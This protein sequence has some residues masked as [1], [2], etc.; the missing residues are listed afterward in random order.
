MA[1]ETT[2]IEKAMMALAQA[3]LDP[4]AASELMARL[5]VTKDDLKAEVAQEIKAEVLKEIEDEFELDADAGHEPTF[6]GLESKRT[7]QMGVGEFETEVK[8][9]WMV[10]LDG[11]RMSALIPDLIRY[12]YKQGPKALEGLSPAKLLQDVMIMFTKKKTRKDFKNAV[13]TELAHWLTCGDQKITADWLREKCQPG[14]II[15]AALATFEV[16]RLFF[17]DLWAVLPG[18]LTTPLTMLAGQTMKS[19]SSLALMTSELQKASVGT[20]TTPN[21]G[22]MS[23]LTQSLQS[24]GGLPQLLAASISQLS[25]ATSSPSAEDGTAKD[26]PVGSI[27]T[28]TPRKR[29]TRAA[30]PVVG[31][32]Q[33]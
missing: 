8:I 22:P 1:I 20:G 19:I 3:G 13:Y 6:D 25:G 11:E 23:G 15:R 5:T 30:K 28:K 18:E 17:T 32:L 24:M 33:G 10:S 2:E 31:G 21:G 27:T 16:N 9:R 12:V 29:I 26:T 7:I 4:D 14:Q